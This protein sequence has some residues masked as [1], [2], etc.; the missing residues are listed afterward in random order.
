MSC[1]PYHLIEVWQGN[2]LQLQWYGAIKEGGPPLDLTGATAKFLVKERLEDPDDAAL[3]EG[4][5]ENGKI[6]LTDPVNGKLVG[7]ISSEDSEDLLAQSN[8]CPHRDYIAQFKVVLSTGQGVRSANF[9]L[10][11]HKGAIDRMA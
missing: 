11:F 2:E 6:V 9:V 5:T 7:T 3:I 8:G 10:R 4:T 1:T